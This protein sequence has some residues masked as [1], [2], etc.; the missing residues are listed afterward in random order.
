M[1]PL[2]LIL[3]I[4][5]A[6]DVTRSAIKHT[7]ADYQRSRDSAVKEAEKEAG[8][9]SLPRPKQD[10]LV[11]RHRRGYLAAE[12][13]H[14]F[15]VTRTGWHAGWLAHRTARTHARA[16]R[17]EAR[18][19]DAETR[20]SF[21]KG[22]R[23]HRERQRQA[24]KEI[25]QAI[26]AWGGPVRGKEE[27]GKAVANVVPFPR[28]RPGDAPPLPADVGKPQPEAE[29][30]SV[31]YWAPDIAQPPV[32]P[33]R[34][35]EPGPYAP[36]R[37]DKQVCRL[38]SM[39]GSDADP[40]VPAG[41]GVAHRSHI[42]RGEALLAGARAAGPHTTDPSDGLCIPPADS[43]PMR[44][45][46][47]EDGGGDPGPPLLETDDWPTGV[48]HRRNG[49]APSPATNGGTHMS[50]DTTYSTTLADAKAAHAQADEDTTT[51][52]GR[53]ASAEGAVDALTAANVDPAVIDEQLAYADALGRAETALTEAGEH[54]ASVETLTQRYHGQMQEAHDDAPGAVASREFHGGS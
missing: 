6:W 17:E 30:H 29:P 32:T 36:G 54:A 9:T 2:F 39:P 25:E 27:V 40:L 52:R 8:G 3:I 35:P 50:A 49:G 20:A 38:C 10:A 16:V 13:L 51:I 1:A 4:V 15:P 37:Q 22:L 11:R 23:E 42:E 12:I 43:A 33:R 44:I 14:G 31:S 28:R 24:G 18:T 26:I 46:L 21:V 5:A 34:P 41:I 19:T 7:S 48:P 53:K 45:E 47:A